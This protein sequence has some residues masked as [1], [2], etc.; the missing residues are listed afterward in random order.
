[1]AKAPEHAV[2]LFM[3]L[4]IVELIMRMEEE[5]EF[6]IPSADAQ[7]LETVG[8]LHNYVVEKLI[9]NSPQHNAANIKDEIWNRLCG[10]LADEFAIPLDKIRP[11][12]SFVHDLDMD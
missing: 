4:E 7:Q 2:R 3:G 11:E 6:E 10:I 5:F 12:A 8:A 9:H 1:V